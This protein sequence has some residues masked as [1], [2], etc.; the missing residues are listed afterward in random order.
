MTDNLII[1]STFKWQTWCC[2]LSNKKKNKETEC[3]FLCG[4][5]IRL[6]RK[7]DICKCLKAANSISSWWWS[8]LGL[9]FNLQLRLLGYCFWIRKVASG[10]KKKNALLW[11][12]AK[13][14]QQFAYWGCNSVS[15]F[16]DVLYQEAEW[17]LLCSDFEPGRAGTAH[18]DSL[19][20]MHQLWH[21]GCCWS[22]RVVGDSGYNAFLLAPP[23]CHQHPPQCRRL[24]IDS[25][26]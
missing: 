21:N 15:S 19:F 26:S 7:Q 20:V 3:L 2:C 25:P 11:I 13:W 12:W 14:H 6:D 9:L 23:A 4:W 5:S 17:W 24:P 18:P 8:S 1:V 10:V 22:P 16:G